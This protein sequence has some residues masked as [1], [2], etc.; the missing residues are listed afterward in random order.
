M[1]AALG[2]NPAARPRTPLWM[3]VRV[4]WPDGMG[5]MKGAY[6]DRNVWEE[7]LRGCPPDRFVWEGAPWGQG[8]ERFVWE[9]APEG[10][11][12]ERFVW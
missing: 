10:R 5:V 3:G 6:P 4:P 11:R 2:F 9:E 8:P 1:G 7:A 12:P